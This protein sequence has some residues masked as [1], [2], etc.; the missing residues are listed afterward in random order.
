LAWKVTAESPEDVT[1]EPAR[2][3]RP[4]SLVFVPVPES[5]VTKNRLHLDLATTS[6]EEQT[7]MVEQLLNRGAVRADIGQ[8]QV[9][10]VVLADPE[11]NEF[12]VL[13]PHERYQGGGRLASV[14]I[15]A[16]DPDGLARFWVEATGWSIGFKS[17]DIVRLHRTG[18]QPPYVEFL[19][20]RDAKTAKNRLHL[21][22]SARP[23]GNRVAE[24]DRLIS[25]GARHVDIG[26]GSEVPWV[27]LAD[28]EGNEF[29]ILV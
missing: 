1:V 25:L 26:Q 17:D 4:L 6:L 24:A 20:V 7:A 10:W 13:A 28:P 11:G 19:R 14:V 29:C 21:D 12:C 16:V 9:S 22:V 8:G 23:N 2:E 15:D 3:D 27:V 5:K 18:E